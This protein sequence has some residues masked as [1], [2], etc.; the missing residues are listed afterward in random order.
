MGEELRMEYNKKEGRQHF[1]L[2]LAGALA[3]SM[4]LGLLVYFNWTMYKAAMLGICG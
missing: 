4:L 2:A 3:P 1:W